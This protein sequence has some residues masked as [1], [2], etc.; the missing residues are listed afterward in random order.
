MLPVL[1]S[2]RRLGAG[3]E[4]ADADRLAVT[5]GGEQVRMEVVVLPASTKAVLLALE[6]DDRKRFMYDRSPLSGWDQAE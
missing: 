6:R 2:P 5:E 3:G 1:G 4:F